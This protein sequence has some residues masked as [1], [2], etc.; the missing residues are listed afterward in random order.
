MKPSVKE[1]TKIDK[2]TKSY[3]MNG[4]K[5][6]ARIWVEQNVYQILKNIEP[7]I[8]GQP[9]AEVLTTTDRRF[10]HYKANEDRVIL[11]TG[12]LLRNYYG[13]TGSV[14]N[15]QILVPKQLVSE[16]VRSLHGGFRRHPGITTTKISYRE[17]FHY[18]NMAQL[19]K[20]WLMSIEQC[21]KESRINRSLSSPP[22]QILIDITTTPEDAMQIDLVPESHPSVAMK[23]L[24]Q[25]WTWFAAI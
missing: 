12:L 20:G 15:Y 1:F 14:R 8:L 7:K 5:E 13:E 24:L 21:I 25:P 23:T 16:V 10:R 4:T 22:H 2:N 18:P 17:K 3:S 11:K 6:N 19:I 9:H